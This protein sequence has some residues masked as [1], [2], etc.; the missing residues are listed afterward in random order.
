MPKGRN[1][2]RPKVGYQY[3]TDSKEIMYVL[4]EFPDNEL[5]PFLA[6]DSQGNFH[7]YTR[8]GR[9][10][11]GFGNHPLHMREEIKEDSRE[12]FYKMYGGKP[13]HDR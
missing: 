12:V 5:Y 1:P 7:Q 10:F 11:H 13:K 9:Y 6:E 2:I 3:K 4:K 8:K